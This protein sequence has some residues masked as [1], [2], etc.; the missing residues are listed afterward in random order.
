GFL[1]RAADPWLLQCAPEAADFQ[2][3]G[4]GLPADVSG[5]R[6]AGRRSLLERVSSRLEG[7]HRDRLLDDHDARARQ[8]FDLIDS[9][10]ARRAFPSDR[11]APHLR[12]R[13][14]RTR[15]GQSCLLARR[16]VE[17]GV[18]FVRVNWSRVPGAHN[19]GHWD[20]HGRNTAALRQLMPIMDQG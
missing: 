7:V 12:D 9:P 11:E 2:V 5:P 4:L 18:P 6:F 10:Q 8:A 20:T 14:G 13:Y 1:G 3:T 16:L 15:F 19:N 17:A